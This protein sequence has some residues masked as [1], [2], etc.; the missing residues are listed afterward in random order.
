M[1]GLTASQEWGDAIYDVTNSVLRNTCSANGGGRPL[2]ARAKS[3][4]AA[5]G[6]HGEYYL[7]S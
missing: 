4:T 1:S 6:A 3:S 5:A 2:Q 7:I